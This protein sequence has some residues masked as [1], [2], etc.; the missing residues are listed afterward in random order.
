[1]AEEEGIDKQKL[2]ATWDI[3]DPIFAPREKAALE[4]ATLFSE[5]YHAISD[6]H[7]A[8][9]RQF[10]SEEELIELGAFLAICD[11]FGKLVEMLGLG[12]QEQTCEYEV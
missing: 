4:M 3:D 2:E 6:E 11:G 8:K 7:F 12:Q 5:D 9:W 10:F 1:V